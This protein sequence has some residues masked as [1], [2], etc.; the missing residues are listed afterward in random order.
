[1]IEQCV[2]L[3]GG[4]GSRLGEL[5]RNTPK[6]LLPVADRPFLEWLVREVVRQG[7]RRIVLLAAFESEQIQDFARRTGAKFGVGIE[8]SIEPERAGTGGALWHAREMLDD[9]FFLM[10]G[11]SFLDVL[12]ADIELMFRASSNNLGVLAL[13]EIDDA[14]RFGVVELAG[15]R[16]V[17]FSARPLGPGPG[18][19]NG[20]VYAFS[21][22]IVQ[23]LREQSSLEVDVMPELVASGRLMGVR[24]RAYFI[25]I[26]VPA[27]YELAQSEIPLKLTRPAVFFDRDGVLNVDHGHVGTRDRFEWQLGAREAIRAVNAAGYLAFVITNQAGI[28]KGYYS[29]ADFHDLMDHVQGELSEIGA[30]LDDIRYCPHHPEAA[31]ETYCRKSDWR[32]PNPGMLLDLMNHWDID[33]ESSFVVGDKD[34]DLL[35]AERAGLRGFLFDGGN[36]LDFLRCSTPFAKGVQP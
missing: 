11:D 7:V 14:S 2:I 32:K 30:H 4:L 25:D 6:P 13:R 12:L 8:V 23:H 24:S 19:V 22:E 17:S 15:D 26:G 10:N 34:S 27:S 1:M 5:T 18:L 31:I 28:G 33:V 29:E 21:R 3:C 20:G 16:V 9:I 36:L 35:A